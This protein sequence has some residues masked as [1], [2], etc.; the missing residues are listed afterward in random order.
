MSG[1]LIFLPAQHMPV[2][3]CRAFSGKRYRKS[4]TVVNPKE[5]NTG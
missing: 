2:Y 1:Q 3:I 5:S 4:V